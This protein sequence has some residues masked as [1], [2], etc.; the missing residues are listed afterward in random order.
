MMS[1]E[2]R[3]GPPQG[4]AR[5]GQH[6]QKLARSAG[7]AIPRCE[8]LRDFS[9][10]VLGRYVCN[11]FDEALGTIGSHPFD[12]IVLGG[13]SFGPIFAQQLLYGDASRARRI[14]LVEAARLLLPEH[15]QN[16]PIL[17]LNVPPPTTV[18]PWVARNEVWGLP[19]RSDVLGG[20]VY[21]LGGR[22]LF[23]GGWSPRRRNWRAIGDAKA[24]RIVPPGLIA[25]GR[26][27]PVLP[28]TPR[29]TTG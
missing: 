1:R 27:V 9:R 6:C 24:A 22:L 3:A 21:A 4:V 17:G 14:L 11:G 16:L 28:A 26:H 5:L 25:N 12:V 13:G 15:V 2:A 23:F 19:W 10:D 18:D 20:L 29:R 7:R 8:A